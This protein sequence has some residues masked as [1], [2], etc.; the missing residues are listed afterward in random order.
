MWDVSLGEKESE[1]IFRKGQPSQTCTYAN[2]PNIKQLMYEDGYDKK[3]YVWILSDSGQGVQQIAFIGRLYSAGQEQDAKIVDGQTTRQTIEMWGEPTEIS[4]GNDP[5][6]RTYW[7]DAYNLGLSFD[8]DKA[9]A[10]IVGR[11]SVALG[12]SS[13]K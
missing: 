6:R 10:I 12:E 9:V 5:T 11:R 1:L 13:C 3:D 8:T 7:F 4:P 2:S